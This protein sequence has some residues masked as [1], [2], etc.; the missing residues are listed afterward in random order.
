MPG[1]IGSIRIV[2]TLWFMTSNPMKMELVYFQ[3]IPLIVCTATMFT[4]YKLYSDGVPV[5]SL[6]VPTLVHGVVI[7]IFKRA[8]NIA[9]LLV[10]LFI[11][12]LFL[13]AKGVKANRFPFSIEGED[14]NDLPDLEELYDEATE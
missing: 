13:F 11:D 12:I 14:E 1:I 3:L 2:I 9:P 7:F 6:I 5:I 4:F 10:L 8:I